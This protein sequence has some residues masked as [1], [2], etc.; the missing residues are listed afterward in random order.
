METKPFSKIQGKTKVNLTRL[1]E[2]HSLLKNLGANF[3]LKL[4]RKVCEHATI[5]QNCR[6]SMMEIWAVTESKSRKASYPGHIS[7]ITS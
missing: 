3:G 2:R 4:P 1:V 5:Q 6:F 7:Q